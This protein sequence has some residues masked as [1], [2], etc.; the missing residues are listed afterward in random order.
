MLTKKI[1]KEM[2]QGTFVHCWGEP[3]RHSHW[4]LELSSKGEKCI[5]CQI[6]LISIRHDKNLCLCAPKGICKVF[7][8]ILFIITPNWKE[9]KCLSRME[10]T[11]KLW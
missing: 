2:N 10:W 4:K 8:A 1:R 6:A 7:I 3:K 5:P 11:N 9:T